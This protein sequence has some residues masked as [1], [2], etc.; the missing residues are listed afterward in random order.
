MAIHKSKFLVF[1]FLN[2]QWLLH[3][4]RYV[5]FVAFLAILYIYNGHRANKA[6]RNIKATANQVKYL[7]AAYKNA[8][9]KVMASTSIG[10]LAAQ[11]AP[12][13]IAESNEAPFK[14]IKTDSII[15]PT[16]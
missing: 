6:V 1:K 9:S 11:A 7:E 13:G 12:L 14:I 10:A 15:K 5:L 8:K 2:S 4:I 16:K 3:N